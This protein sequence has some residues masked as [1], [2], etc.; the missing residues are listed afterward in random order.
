VT[1]LSAAT[2]AAE[3]WLLHSG[4]QRTDP[5]L[6]TPG[7]VRAWFDRTKGTYS[8]LYSEITG[9]AITSL[10]NFYN[11]QADPFYLDRAELAA[12]WLIREAM[13]PSGAVLCRQHDTGWDRTR[14]AFDAGM[15]MNGLVNLYKRTAKPRHLAAAQAI[16]DWLTGSM[17]RSDGGFF[18][19]LNSETGEP[20]NTGEKWSTISGSFLVKLAIGLLNLADATGDGRYTE[21]AKKLC[22]WGLGLQQADGR[23]P[24]AQS[25]SNTF[26]HPHC[27]TAEGLLVAGQVLG[28]QSWAEAVAKA[29][30][31]I[32]PR[33]LAD[34]EFPAHFIGG[35]FVPVSSPDITAQVLR[36]WL[37]LPPGLQAA[38]PLDHRAAIDAVVRAQC[39]DR[40]AQEAG[41]F[42]AGAAWFFGEPEDRAGEHINAWVTMFAHQTLALAMPNKASFDPFLMV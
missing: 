34:G 24:S 2:Q 3:G 18:S 15:V 10:V 17:Q 31:W 42:P 14:Y 33:Q 22:G 32:A 26:L 12:D 39:R 37:L 9:Y 21:A 30:A 13:E 8:F 27:Y 7:G 41:G 25:S 28:E 36:L 29:V 40:S 19:K 1:N 35:E 4:I 11:Y 23:F 16:G 5:V 38:I 20:H 6:G